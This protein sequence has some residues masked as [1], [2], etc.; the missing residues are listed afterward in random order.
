MT[1][2][3]MGGC[4]RD[5]TVNL[6]DFENATD[7]QTMP[8]SSRLP[9]VTSARMS[10]GNATQALRYRLIPSA[11]ISRPAHL[12]AKASGEMMGMDSVRN[13]SR[14]T[15]R[16]SHSSSVMGSS[17]DFIIAIGLLVMQAANQT[18]VIA[19]TS[20]ARD[21]FATQRASAS[22]GEVTSISWYP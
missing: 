16:R 2:P 18:M 4:G 3:E 20:V 12:G 21:P 5:T 11:T 9:S 14:Q 19:V 10:Y 1:W 7:T 22:L 15:R 17:S 6:S 13:R 8:V